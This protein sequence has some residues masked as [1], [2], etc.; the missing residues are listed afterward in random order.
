MQLTLRPRN[1]QANSVPG[2]PLLRN[3]PHRRHA[4]RWALAM[5]PLHMETDNRPLRRKPKVR[6]EGKGAEGDKGDERDEGTRGSF[7]RR[8]TA[9]YSPIR[10]EPTA[11]RLP[12][13]PLLR[14][15]HFGTQHPQLGTD[16]GGKPIVQTPFNSAL[17]G[18]IW[19]SRKMG[20][21][22]ASPPTFSKVPTIS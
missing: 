3:Y 15:G 20:P 8:C 18:I 11:E 7:C 2:L 22:L 4:T 6:L 14:R 16:G 9:K 5:A 13:Q 1:P 19:T 17:S 21:W 12:S 10:V